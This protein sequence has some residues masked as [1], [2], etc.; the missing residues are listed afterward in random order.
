MLLEQATELGRC[1]HPY[2]KE[3]HEPVD[4]FG[5]VAAAV[6]VGGDLARLAHRLER[7]RTARQRELARRNARYLLEAIAECLD[8][9]ERGHV[10]EQLFQVGAVAHDEGV[11][12]GEFSQLLL[13]L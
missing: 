10:A 3:G 8:P 4:R 5:E 9:A 11:A 13:G 7:A 6:E 2:I 1:L 12:A